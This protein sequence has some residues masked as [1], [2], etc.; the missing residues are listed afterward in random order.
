M[1]AFFFAGCQLL[2]QAG[3]L[4]VQ[5]SKPMPCN[6]FLS[7]VGKPASGKSRV[8]D[9]L[10]DVIDQTWI[11]ELPTGSVESIEENLDIWRFSYLI[12]DEMGELGEKSQSYL[13]RVKYLLNKAYYLDRITRGRTTKKTVAISRKSYYLSVILAGLPEDWKKIEAKF[14][15]GFERRFLPITIHRARL[16]FE[17]DEPQSEEALGHQAKL[18]QLINWMEDKAFLV[19]ADNLSHFQKSTLKVNERYWSLIEEYAYKLNAVLKL[20]YI[21]AIV[22]QMGDLD[23]STYQ[24]FL[25]PLPDSTLIHSDTIDTFKIQFDTLIQNKNSPSSFWINVPNVSM[26]DDTL[27]FV[28]RSLQGII[29]IADEVLNRCIQRIN[30]FVSEKGRIV[31]RK[32]EFVHEIL[33]ISNA[34]Y[35]KKV[36]TALEDMERVRTVI[37]SNKKHYVV[38]DPKARICFNCSEFWNCYKANKHEFSDLDPEEEMDCYVCES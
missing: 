6:F 31:V 21:T 38:L 3:K 17:P 27:H 15:G 12:W 10:R 25:E 4:F 9:C 33:K 1:E 8:I 16:P 2:A 18:V 23:V 19:N 34:D 36:V 5:R 35:Y 29:D 28:V 32:R 26:L 22:E 30:D 7:I 14:L 24:K 37:L 13:D 11:Y 20:N